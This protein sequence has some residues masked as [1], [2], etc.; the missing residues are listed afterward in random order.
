[1]KILLYGEY[2]EGTHV[3]SISIVLNEKKIQNTVFNFDSYLRFNTRSVLINKTLRRLFY[4]LNEY[5]I[6]IHLLKTIKS[7]KPNVLVI[8]KGINIYSSTLKKIKKFDI[9]ICNWNPDD[10]FNTMNSS[11]HLKRSFK[12]YDIVFSARKHLFHEYYSKGF[13]KM[14]YLDWYFIP[15]LHKLNNFSKVNRK[16]SFIG[17]RSLRREKIINSIDNSFLIDVWGSGWS[18]SKLALKDNIKIKKK[19]LDQKYFPEIISS[20]LVNLNILTIENRDRTNLKIFEI[21]AS[22]GFLLTEDNIQC[23]EL[24]GDFG[25]YYDDSNLNDVLKQ[26]FEMELDEYN[27]KRNLMYKQLIKNSNSI[28]DRVDDLLSHIRSLN[29]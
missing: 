1:M 21:I 27:S 7:F 14:I 11:I 4:Y 13:K 28:Y 5:F 17:T 2:W 19:V 9:I 6:N 18:H 3:D 20:S 8:S 16:I 24:L 25:F 29:N 10:F 23:R 26:I 22:G 12:I 15:W